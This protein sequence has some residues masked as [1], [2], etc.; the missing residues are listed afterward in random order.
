MNESFL[1]DIYHDDVIITVKKEL[2]FHICKLVIS[3]QKVI[4]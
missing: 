4:G 2:L 3:S 1:V